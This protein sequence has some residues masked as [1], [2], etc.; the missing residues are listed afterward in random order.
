MNSSPTGQAEPNPSLPLVQR[1]VAVLWPSFVLAGIATTAFFAVFDPHELVA[2]T[3]FPQMSRL[4]AY[5]I[6]FFAFWLLTAASST[7]TCYFRRPV[8]GKRNA[9]AP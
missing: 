9:D 6:G 7:M 2:P 8:S 3:W 1:L 5:S 4:G